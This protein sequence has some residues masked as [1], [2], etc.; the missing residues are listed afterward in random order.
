[1]IQLTA[2]DGTPV[3]IDR[4]CIREVHPLGDGAIVFLKTQPPVRVIQSVG[5][6]VALWKR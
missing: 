4:G 2:P 6:I 1:M 5:W 3:D